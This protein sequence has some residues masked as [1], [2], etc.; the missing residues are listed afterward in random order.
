MPGE[1]A[2]FE[3]QEEPGREGDG[4]EYQLGHWSSDGC[5]HQT[6]DG[7][8]EDSERLDLDEHVRFEQVVDADE[9]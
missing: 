2:D 1:A 9:R 4:Q 8:T 7:K 5:F 3:G 6:F